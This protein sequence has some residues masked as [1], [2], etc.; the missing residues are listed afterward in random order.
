MCESEEASGTPS[1]SVIIPVR[2][3]PDDLRSCLTRLGASE[4][5]RFEIII[6]DDASTDGTASVADD[7]GL[8]CIVLATN[9]GPAFARNRGAE[10]ARAEILVFI[11]ADVLV[12]SD[13]LKK[14]V[15]AFHDPE[16]SAVFGSYDTQPTIQTVVSQYKN[17]A[18]HFVHQHAAENASTFWTGCGAIRS[19]V[20]QAM[21]GF[22][23]SYTQ[24]CIEDIELGI[25]MR[26]AGLAIRLDRQIQVTHTK[27]WTLWSMIRTDVLARGVPWSRLI[28]RDG[29]IENDLNL[30]LSQRVCVLLTALI[31]SML[32]FFCWQSP[33]F[34]WLPAG[35][36]SGIAA[37]DWPHPG[38]T[39]RRQAEVLI[40]LTHIGLTIG[41]VVV[42]PVRM[43]PILILVAVVLQLNRSLFMFFARQ[44]GP[45]FAVCTI[46]LQM[47]YY[48]YSAVA[49]GLG[50][51]SHWTGK[52]R[53]NSA[54]C[55]T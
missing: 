49:F 3:A 20:F 21:G 12:H 8:E 25:R 30:R 36:F 18:H 32:G 9:S 16:C 33:V 44:R 11:D 1:V 29:Q 42:F 19:E 31:C 52:A 41:F 23:E 35:V 24:P 53:G 6:V 45:A 34:L 51:V 7:F 28:L 4:H 54:T 37:S 26:R 13:T 43:I 40:V 15:D 5:C 48:F 38:K 2:N 17:L 22:S 27:R 39:V 55:A 14:F 46:S 50:L 47:L 10:K